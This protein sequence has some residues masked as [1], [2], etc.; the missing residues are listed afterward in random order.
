MKATRAQSQHGKPRIAAPDPPTYDWLLAPAQPLT[1]SRHLVLLA[2]CLLHHLLALLRFDAKVSI[3]GDDAWYILSALDFW[4]GHAFPEWHG[5]F[6]PI[7][8]SP[9]VGLGGLSIPWIKALSMLFSTAALYLMGRWLHGRIAR[10]AWLGTLLLCALCSNLV[11]LASS[12]YS[13][14]LFML[15][16]AAVLIL[17]THVLT[18]SHKTLAPQSLWGY[19]LLGCLL[20]LLA[21][22]RYVGLG[23]LIALL[24][25]LVIFARDWRGAGLTLGGF[26]LFQIPFSLYKQLRW[27]LGGAAFQEQLS[28]MLQK[29][30]YNADQGQEGLGGLLVRMGENAQ[31]YL[32]YHFGQFIGIPLERGNLSFPLLVILLGL[33][34]L[35]FR[36]S[37][38]PF[39]IFLATYLVVLLGITFLT[40]QA[41]WNQMRL[42]V[43]Y[44]PLL[45]AFALNGLHDLLSALSPKIARGAIYTFVALASISTLATNLHAMT[46]STLAAN[47]RGDQYAGLT[48]DWEN[49]L[50]ASAW[51]GKNLPD[52]AIIAARKPN[53]ARIYAK[54][55][56]LGIFKLVAQHRD[57]VWQYF[58]SH[59]VDY[60]LIG[61]LRINPQIRTDR[62]I[63]SMHYNLQRLLEVNPACLRIV[64]KEG[65]SEPAYLFAFEPHNALDHPEQ[66][67]QALQDGRTIYPDNPE[68]LHKLALAYLLA[69]QPAL[70]QPYI[71]QG[72]AAIAALN[73]HAA[74]PFL[75]LQA[76]A[77]YQ[78]G[79]PQ[80]AAN[81]LEQLLEK[82]PDSA[83]LWQQYAK[84]LEALKSPKAHAARLRANALSQGKPTP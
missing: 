73:S 5:A 69:H 54:R 10:P 43:V 64:H 46:P 41:K 8:L 31:Q 11:Y 30:F 27:Q 59:H 9:L 23:A 22:T 18:F 70:A 68:A 29:D 16:Q 21:L 48:P 3:G 4:H 34:I 66:Y 78:Q 12:T 45:L 77:Y 61:H 6:Y 65:H 62:F 44:L 81:L 32:G 20:F 37:R 63:N 25:Y 13:E 1:Q 76:M 72:L 67:L 84:A 36:R 80:Q 79:R 53:N 60:I 74:T 38:K 2:I 33:A 14:P 57:S 24:L 82:E 52:S 58:R 35:I 75:Q 39:P 83:S 55:P 47:L 28:H 40:Q 50:R 71:D 15:L 7:L 56:F 19:L 51:A 26:L 49:Y 17:F 42:V